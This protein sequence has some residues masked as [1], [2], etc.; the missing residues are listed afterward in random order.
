[1]RDSG[2]GAVRR[3][4]GP[5]EAFNYT[6]ASV[7]ATDKL[8]A[9]QPDVAAAAVRAIVKTQ[10]ALKRDVS[11]AT[12]VGRKLFPAPEAGL[13]ATLIERD[14]PYYDAAITPDFVAG[15]SRFAHDL[16]LIAQPLAYEQVVAAQFAPLWQAT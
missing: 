10:N 7:A 16:G 13:I 6:M 15:M 12:Q 5:R 3:G 14:L 8:I 11:L 1:M 4:N 2:R 9:E